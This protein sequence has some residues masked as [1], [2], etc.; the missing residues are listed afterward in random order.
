M[1]TTAAHWREVARAQHRRAIE[2]TRA[3]L[4]LRL[5]VWLWVL[6]ADAWA[7]AADLEGSAI[8]R[9]LYSKRQWVAARRLAKAASVYAAAVETKAVRPTQ[10]GGRA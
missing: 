10:P 9:R 7:R 1:T 2:G 4:E 5:I 3:G 6:A 8:R